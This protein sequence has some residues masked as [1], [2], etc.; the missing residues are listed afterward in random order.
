MGRAVLSIP[1]GWAVGP[2]GSL[3]VAGYQINPASTNG[4]IY[5]F[6]ANT[7]AYEGTFVTGSSLA[8]PQG[9]AFGPNGDLYVSNNNPNFGPCPRTSTP[10]TPAGIWPLRRGRLEP[11][12]HHCVSHSHRPPEG[13]LLARTATSISPTRSATES[14]NITPTARSFRPLVWD[15]ITTF[16]PGTGWAQPSDLAFGP[17]GHLFVTDNNGISQFDFTNLSSLEPWPFGSAD[18][19]SGDFIV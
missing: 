18:T 6:N 8:E 4:A 17:Q 15:Y 16:N 9:I 5:K 13:W 11:G 7:G 1:R 3:Y 14:T 2:D 12:R 19:S 10:T